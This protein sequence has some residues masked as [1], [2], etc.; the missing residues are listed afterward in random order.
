[1]PET[2][3][4]FGSSFSYTSS[5]RPAGRIIA[6]AAAKE[7]LSL[8]LSGSLQTLPIELVLRIIE[9]LAL[10]LCDSA[11][12]HARPLFLISRAVRQSLL[13]LLY[14]ALVIDA[15]KTSR[16]VGQPGAHPALSFLLW[17][18]G[19]PSAEPRR[20]I[21]NLALCTG[22][23]SVRH[24]F[25][26]DT[27]ASKPSW[28]LDNLIL[29][30]LGDAWYLER[31]GICTRAAHWIECI[32]GDNFAESIARDVISLAPFIRQDSPKARGCLRISTRP[33]SDTFG[34]VQTNRQKDALKGW[35]GAFQYLEMDPLQDYN[36]RELPI[37]SRGVFIFIDVGSVHGFGDFS[38]AL[39]D[40]IALI[41]QNEV[42]ETLHVVLVYPKGEKNVVIRDTAESLGARCAAQVHDRL[43]IASS[44]ADRKLIARD[45]YL[46]IARAF[47]QGIDPWDTGRRITEIIVEHR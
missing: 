3:P 35:A 17:L 21:K 36:V 33:A 19:T 34:F 38:V 6:M 27:K 45:P 10:D 47:Q 8:E 42:D 14:G 7:S 12:A 32:T 40:E 29:T 43:W 2:E 31:A 16:L 25:F 1:M 44:S 15:D 24:L 26:S 39:L 28:F 20:H 46:G 37:H 18:L 30:T 4:R 9:A 22:S 23:A 13:P 11:P 5:R 41:F